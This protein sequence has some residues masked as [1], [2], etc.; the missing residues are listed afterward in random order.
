MQCKVCTHP[1]KPRLRPAKK[2]EKNSATLGTRLDMKAEHI[3]DYDLD[4]Y[5]FGMVTEE[6]ELAPLEEHIL[7]CPSCA[8]EEVQDYVD[9]IRVAA[10]DYLP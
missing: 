4:R 7:C 1:N 6:E 9:G 3:S 2:C 10:Y 8:E 5:C